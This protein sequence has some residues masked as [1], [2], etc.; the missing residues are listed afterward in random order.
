M[1]IEAYIQGKFPIIVDI[2]SFMIDRGV[3]TGTNALEV[4]QQNRDLLYAD[5]CAFAAKMPS[6][7]SGARDTDGQW[8]HTD[9]SYRLT[10]EDRSF[11]QKEANR[12]YKLYND[13]AYRPSMIMKGLNG[14]P[15]YPEQ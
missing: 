9:S 2:S 8:S 5:T 3:D 12:I 6:S 13:A 15:Y 11:Y 14:T 10:N 7:Q 1:T 4:S